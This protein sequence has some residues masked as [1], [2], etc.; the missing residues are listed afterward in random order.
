M[1]YRIVGYI[2]NAAGFIA[3]LYAALLL[4]LYVGMAQAVPSALPADVDVLLAK[5]EAAL[6]ANDLDT[7]HALSDAK[8]SLG[9]LPSRVV[10]GKAKWKLAIMPLPTTQRPH[11]PTA[12]RPNDTTTQ[13]PND[14]TAQ[15]PNNPT[16]QRPNDPTTQ[17]PHDPTTQRPNDTT[18]R[19][20][21]V[22]YGY[23]TVQSIGDHFHRLVKR[24]DGWRFG[25]EIPETET[26]GFRV[27]DH[28]LTVKF[29]PA[30]SSCDIT[31]N[32][33]VERTAAPPNGLCLLRLSSVLHVDSVALHAV[34]GSSSDGVALSYWT[35]PGCIAVRAPE[36]SNVSNTSKRFTLSLKYHGSYAEPG[37]DSYINAKEA[38]LTSYWWPHIARL[39][40]KHGV[41][42][43]V[44][45][46][47]T[48][49]GEG[50]LKD[51][52]EGARS[53]TFTFRN[54]IPV[55]YFSLDAAPYSIT[56]RQIAGRKISTCLLKPDPARAKRA[57]DQFE[58]ALPFFEKTFGP[59]PYTHYE[60]VETQGPFGGALEA[61]S[62]ATYGPGSFD[63]VVHELAH[64]WWGGLLPNTYLT[65]MWNESFAD[66]SD[67]L[68][69]RVTRGDLTGPALRGQ[70]R[71]PDYGRRLL[72]AYAVPVLKAFDT[73]NG[74]HAS[75]GYGKGAQA[76][77]MLEDLLGREM[78]LKCVR[79]FR[80]DHVKGEPADWADFAGALNKE[81]GRDYGW[82]FEQWL[83]RGGVAVV[84]LAGAKQAEGAVTLDI[85]QEGVP[86]RLRIPVTIE[87]A[88][89][90]I[91][92][93][94]VE[95]KSSR[96]SVSIPILSI[97]KKVTLDPDGTLLIAG[98][99]T[100]D[101]K[102]DPFTC[103]F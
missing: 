91:V 62:F 71:A 39:P 4:P 21:A 69:S 100:E 41:T 76:L 74:G 87:L 22:F 61:Y 33:L 16:T 45:K 64:T 70:H 42:V 90:Q 43:T 79:R 36:K 9:W 7:L 6:A 3:A 89:G 34:D 95:V 85:A 18:T 77:A 28:A 101:P 66:Y 57:L 80:A 59:F 10:A 27:R 25:E 51:R 88:N 86:Y 98:L 78:M 38:S 73:S 103:S 49:I 46:G 63:A 12:Q 56:S 67:E 37:M 53:T 97:A 92:R 72:G 15:R 83:N 30:A 65:T 50:E 32:V 52:K 47:W 99:K 29:S 19:Y 14:P 35:T 102:V 48:A 93:K 11:D 68:E 31:D 26:L 84:G 24:A 23:H 55:C 20:L 82:F 58:K 5:G 75:V 44:P 94:I 54:E 1:S 17:R 60:M 81:T 2:S 40:A 8:D 96:E 13:R